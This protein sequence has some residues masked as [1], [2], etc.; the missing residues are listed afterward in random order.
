MIPV[1]N[2]TSQYG[3]CSEAKRSAVT[4]KAIGAYFPSGTLSKSV[5]MSQRI[6]QPR[7]N[8]SSTTGTIKTARIVRHDKIQMLCSSV[9][10]IEEW[11]W[12]VI[13]FENKK[14]CR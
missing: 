1:T 14:C 6:N 7:Q 11:R 13:E 3:P 12:P 9:G 10:R 2:P 8:S 5:L 4:Q